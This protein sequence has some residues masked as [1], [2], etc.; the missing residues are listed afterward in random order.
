MPDHYDTLGVARDATGD[1]IRGAYRKLASKWHPDRNEAPDAQERFVAIQTAY[2]TLADDERRAYYDRTGAELNTQAD[3][4]ARAMILQEFLAE[5]DRR[6]WQQ[7]EY[8]KALRAKFKT[9]RRNAENAIVEIDARLSRIDQM[10]PIGPEDAPDDLF[11]GAADHARE[12]LRKHRAAQEQ[13]LER[14]GRALELLEPYSDNVPAQQVFIA[15]GT[16]T[17]TGSTVGW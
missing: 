10:L 12:Q 11:R 1:Q 9:E 16:G 3:A 17:A 13:N 6:A 4:Q 15:F 2:D 7:G 8:V 14:F 5:A